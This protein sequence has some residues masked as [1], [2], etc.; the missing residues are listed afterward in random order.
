VD[1]DG[2]LS[3]ANKAARF[4][5]DLW[6]RLNGGLAEEEEGRERNGE[7]APE[8][9]RIRQAHAA[10]EEA[11][12]ALAEAEAER[13]EVLRRVADAAGEAGPGRPSPGDLRS[14]LRGSDREVREMQGRRLLASV[15]LLLERA[16]AELEWD[17]EHTTVAEW[18]SEGSQLKLF[19]VEFSLLDK[20]AASYWQFVPPDPEVCIGDACVDI[21]SVLD[22]EEL[23]LLEA[24]VSEF[25]TRVGLEVDRDEGGVIA[26]VQR[27]I[28]QLEKTIDKAK[29]GVSF[30]TLGAQ[31]LWQDIQ[32]A[33]SLFS[34]AAFSAY[35]LKPLEVRTLQRTVK[36]IVTLVPFLIILIIPMTPVGHVLVFSFI[37]KFFPDFFPSTF[38]ER[39]QNVLKI[40]KGIVPGAGS[41]EARGA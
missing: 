32:Y 35:T 20:Q 5:A 2:A 23:R 9:R 8:S 7:Q 40:Y 21:T 41:P 27:W 4:S 10:L 29:T 38:T 31:M 25:A 34:K 11:D 6:D 36:D 26:G 17:L 19:V 18:D 28:G 12:R 22:P 1:L 16:A 13:F 14:S 30:Y 3:E 24:D 37:Q 15:E 39:R 33:S